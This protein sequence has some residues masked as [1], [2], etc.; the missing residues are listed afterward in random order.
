M[1]CMCV[2]M[3]VLHVTY[4]VLS[5]IEINNQKCQAYK[6]T[7]LTVSGKN[8]YENLEVKTISERKS[9]QQ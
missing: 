5:I 1:I 3:C 8:Y 9:E 7:I 4:I 2:R 6:K